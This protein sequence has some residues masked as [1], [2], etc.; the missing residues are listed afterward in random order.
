MPAK[1]NIPDP[2]RIKSFLMS[3]YI[4]GFA[5]FSINI[6][7]DLFRQLISFSILLSLA[8]LLVYHKNWSRTFIITALIIITG[9]WLIELIGTKTGFPFGE[10]EYSNLLRPLIAGVPL[11]LGLNWLFLVYCSFVITSFIPAAN[12]LRAMA[13]ALLM[14]GYDFLLEPFAIHTGMWTWQEDK[15]PLSNYIAWF[16]IS[17]VFVRLLYINPPEKDNKLGIFLFIY[18][19]GLFA[20]LL[21]TWK[22]LSL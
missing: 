19:A 22:L 3:Y 12:T 14:T 9:G 18:Q 20:A 10:Y 16:V 4:I 1:L 11:I 6:S 17:F 5:G 15:V 13:G 2:E 7:Y 8:L 21:L